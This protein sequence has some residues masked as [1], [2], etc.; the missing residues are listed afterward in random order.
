MKETSTISSFKPFSLTQL[1][2]ISGSV[3]LIDKKM[4]VIQQNQEGRI[5]SKFWRGKSFT[6]GEKFNFDTNSDSFSILIEKVQKCLSKME[7][8]DF[9]FRMNC[10]DFE[11]GLWKV[12]IRPVNS[13]YNEK[14][15]ALIQILDISSMEKKIS[16]IQL[17]NQ[18]LKE[19][20]LKPSHILRS[21]L[22][23][24]LG[25]LE[26]IDEDELGE[27]NQKYFSYLKPLAKE[28]DDVI[29]SNAKKISIFD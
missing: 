2:A 22:S 12:I 5:L 4:K 20:A 6:E 8:S 21:P 19:L 23:S 1:A 14:V 13:L 28:L 11:H 29:R 25:L 27:E 18:L 16:K 26:L 7:S 15:T 24:I 10:N 17:E 9:E 3:W